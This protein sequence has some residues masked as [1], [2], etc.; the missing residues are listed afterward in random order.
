MFKHKLGCFLEFG[1]M[2]KAKGWK[3]ARLLTPQKTSKN[4]QKL[5]SIHKRGA[6]L[7]LYENILGW[8]KAQLLCP[9]KPKTQLGPI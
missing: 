6:R 8:V 5:A 3:K 1:S 9:P 7:P 4:L 2:Q